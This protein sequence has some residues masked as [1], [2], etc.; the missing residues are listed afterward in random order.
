MSLSVPVCVSVCVLVCVPVCVLVCV[1]VMFRRGWIFPLRRGYCSRACV[2]VA[3][4][5]GR[6][7]AS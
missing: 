7:A 2:S 6:G 5:V 1:P 3:D 4:D